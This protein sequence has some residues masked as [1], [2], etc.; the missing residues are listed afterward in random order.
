[1]VSVPLLFGA[2]SGNGSSPKNYFLQ[3][4]FVFVSKIATVQFDISLMKI[5]SPKSGH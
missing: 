3:M 2:L 5:V 4:H 1:M